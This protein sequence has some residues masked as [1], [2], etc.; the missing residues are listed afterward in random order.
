MKFITNKG[1]FLFLTIIFVIGCT[2]PGRYYHPLGFRSI[3]EYEGKLYNFFTPT[4]LTE[5]I[6][7]FFRKNVKINNTIALFDIKTEQ[8]RVI[9]KVNDR[10][11]TAL[12]N[13]Y[14]TSTLMKIRDRFYINYRFSVERQYQVKL[15]GIQFN[16]HNS[17]VYEKN[18]IYLK[19][20]A[21]ITIFTDTLPTNEE[22]IKNLNIPI[23]NGYNIKYMPFLTKQFEWDRRKHIIS[24]AT[25]KRKS[26]GTR[27]EYKLYYAYVYKDGSNQWNYQL[28]DDKYSYLRM[29][30]EIKSA[31]IPHHSLDGRANLCFDY[32]PITNN[33]NAKE[34]FRTRCFILEN[35]KVY[36]KDLFGE[37]YNIEYKNMLDSIYTDVNDKQYNYTFDNKGNMHLFYHK[38]EDIVGKNYDYFWYG[39]FTKDNPTTPFYEQKIYWR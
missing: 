17:V 10:N 2:V 15:E 1:L 12:A 21:N 14:N 22:I 3:I 5:D 37:I 8:W 25:D 33:L 20:D 35:S 18:K 29:A 32:Y 28:I 24:I 7:G 16:N 11:I 9:A 30:N 19:N 36:L 31:N 26:E 4:T 38:R 34:P 6:S 39:Y 27:F 23:V 13:D